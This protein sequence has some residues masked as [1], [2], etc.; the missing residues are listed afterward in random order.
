MEWINYQLEMLVIE[1]VGSL[2]PT[3]AIFLLVRHFLMKEGRIAPL[4]AGLLAWILAGTLRSFGE[5]DGGSPQWLDGFS[6]M[7]VPVLAIV[8]L[9]YMVTKGG[10]IFKKSPR[11]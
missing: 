8:A 4:V 5:A 7:L 11:P 2:I 1:W 10:P 6:F 9:D 3:G